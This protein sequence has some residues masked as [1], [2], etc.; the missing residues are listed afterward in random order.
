MKIWDSHTEKCTIHVHYLNLQNYFPSLSPPTYLTHTHTHTLHAHTPHTHTS[1]MHL[2]HAHT[3][4]CTHT[5][6]THT[7]THSDYLNAHMSCLQ[8]LLS[9]EL[10]L[11]A[12]TLVEEL[13]NE[14]SSHCALFHCLLVSLANVRN[15]YDNYIS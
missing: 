12:I 13:K 9:N 1:H 8:L 11:D 7:H 6:P 2:T 3:H 15:N 4:T 10:W 14:E 5:H